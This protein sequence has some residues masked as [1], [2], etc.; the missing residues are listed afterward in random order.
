[1]DWDFLRQ[2]IARREPT[3][4]I[5][6]FFME[7]QMIGGRLFRCIEEICKTYCKAL[8]PLLAI[9]HPDLPETAT[10]LPIGLSASPVIANWYLKAFDDAVLGSVRPAYYGRYV[11]DILLVIPLREPPEEED[12][13]KSLL[14]ELL[15]K[16]GVI[17]YDTQQ[18]EAERFELCS[19]PGLYLQQQKC[20]V[21][22]FDADHSTAGL[23]KFQ[24]QLE[25]N[26]SDFAL[27]PV[28]EDDSPLAQV[29]YDLLYEG[30]VNKFRSVKAIAANRWSLAVHLAK[31]TQ[32]HLM[33][34]EGLD[35]ELREEL[36]KFFKGSNAINFWDL[37]ERVI[38]LF[39]VAGARDA[40]LKFKEEMREEIYRIQSTK[41]FSDTGEISNDVAIKLRETL[42][43]HL[44]LCTDIGFAVTGEEDFFGFS[45]KWRESN[46]IRH[47]LVAVPLIN[48]TDF[49]GSFANP[50]GASE[51]TI[52]STK[53]MNSPRFVHFDECLSFVSSDCAAQTRKDLIGA[54]NDVYEMFHGS[55]HP[56]ISSTDS[57][58][59]TRRKKK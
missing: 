37:W 57:K 29:A 41:K 58:R 7:E 44:D 14:E 9:T 47:H 22:F 25:E 4:P 15:E 19:R 39:V 10:C 26:A 40:A 38:G 16:A 17:A 56:D 49:E 24:K 8:K 43:G 36:F 34:E 54:A 12:P 30:S 55:P 13:I 50:M 53:A 20:V 46:L 28:E 3:N 51:L 59:I 6:I 23:D 2:Q 1:M 11:D 5:E 33:T 27:L 18:P 32:L 48:Y 35:S 52:N 42:L 45:R 31:Q 21:Q